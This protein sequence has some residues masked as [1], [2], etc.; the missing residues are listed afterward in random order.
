[1]NLEMNDGEMSAERRQAKDVKSII[2]KGPPRPGTNRNVSA[3]P[4]CERKNH[5]Q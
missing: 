2:S 1:M 5:R 4:C 3:H